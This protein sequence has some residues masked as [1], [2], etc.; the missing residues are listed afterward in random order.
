M[1]AVHAAA[2]R[3]L[4]A[5]GALLAAAACGREDR[6]PSSG[7]SGVPP[8][9]SPAAAAP[10]PLS[11]PPGANPDSAARLRALLD[12]AAALD[13]AFQRER[14]VLNADARAMAALDRRSDAYAQRFAEFR[15][16]Q[17]AAESR[18]VER[19]RIR[20]RADAMRGR[21]SG[22]AAPSAPAR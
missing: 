16:R 10:E 1:P 14:A 17:L 4:A 15:A 18:R 2:R 12:S 11:L 19:D 3:S 20:R 9:Q 7:A 6:G 13:S 5:A 21:L 22:A 8:A